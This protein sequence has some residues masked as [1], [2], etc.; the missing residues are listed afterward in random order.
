MSTKRH[1]AA[2]KQKPFD[3]S[4]R[5]QSETTVVTILDP[6]E[7]TRDVDTGI[8]I[9]IASI[10]SREAMDALQE[11]R[12]DVA[13]V[14]DGEEKPSRGRWFEQTIAVTLAWWDINGP[15]DGIVV[16]GEVWACTPEN[17]RRLYES[18]EYGWVQPQVQA[19]FLDLA[20]FFSAPKAS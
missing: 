3:L 4:T 6:A 13:L 19:K 1:T 7:P 18:K 2:P 12:A 16:A 17:V 20:A 8:R 9:K 14:K 10:Y 15:S 11:S 5:R